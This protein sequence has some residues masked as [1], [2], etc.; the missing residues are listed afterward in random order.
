MTSLLKKIKEKGL[1]YKLKRVDEESVKYLTLEGEKFPCKCI[2][3]YDGD[4]VTLIVP[5]L[6]T[7]FKMKCRLYG[8]DTPEKR[9][10]DLFEKQCSYIA[11]DRMKEF[12]EGKIIWSD[13]IDWDKYGRLL[14]NLYPTEKDMKN[15]TNCFNQRMVDEKL[16]YAYD[17]GTKFEFS[18]WKDTFNNGK[19]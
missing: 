1:A 13:C 2:D 17:G 4:T 12:V 16:A 7:F 3:V 18:D 11:R 9:T 5:F 6:G 14:A 19:V 15:N 8:I 10:K